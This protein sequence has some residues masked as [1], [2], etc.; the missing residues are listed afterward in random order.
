MGYLERKKFRWLRND[1]KNTSGGVEFQNA[2]V[3]IA[4]GYEN[5][6]RCCHSD[7]SWLTQLTWNRTRLEAT[8]NGNRWIPRFRFEFEYLMQ[9]DVRNP[10]VAVMID[11]HA[12]WKIEE[13]CSPRV[14][15]F[16]ICGVQ[17]QNGVNVD[18][19]NV[20]HLIV[21]CFIERS[22]DNLEN[23]L[24]E[25]KSIQMVRFTYSSVQIR[26]ARWNMTGWPSMPMATAVT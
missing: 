22:G 23:F 2:I 19:S 7:G 17:F 12:M 13:R 4:V 20:R 25:K 26:S 16:A 3:A 1:A 6:T 18:W 14:Q 11:G 24:S 5:L 15:N 10:N 21:I 9:C 8:A